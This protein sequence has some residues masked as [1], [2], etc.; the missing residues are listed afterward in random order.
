MY[1]Q[2]ELEGDVDFIRL[3]LFRFVAVADFS[4]VDIHLPLLLERTFK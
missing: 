3:S 1:M 2:L 4:Y